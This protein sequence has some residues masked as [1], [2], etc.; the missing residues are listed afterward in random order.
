MTA[1]WLNVRS[2]EY[3]TQVVKDPPEFSLSVAKHHL[4]PNDYHPVKN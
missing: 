2:D 1:A 3:G 4:S